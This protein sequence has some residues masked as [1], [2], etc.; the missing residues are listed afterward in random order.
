MGMDVM[1]QALLLF[2]ATNVDDLLVLSLFFG[3]GDGQHGATARTVTGQ[4]LGFVG[5][6]A[7]AVAAASGIGLLPGTLCAWLG[8][9]PLGLGLRAARREWQAHRK[10]GA[11]KDA[12]AGQQSPNTFGVAAV[13]FSNGGD[14]V[15]AYVPVLA[16]VGTGVRLGYAALFLLL[17]ALWCTAGKLI[18]TRPVCAAHQPLGA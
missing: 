12:H 3:R 18:A 1:G 5:I 15:A 10:A 8:V 6:L 13:T 17:V 7:V 9:L 11:R 2:A 14:N 4:Y 16:A